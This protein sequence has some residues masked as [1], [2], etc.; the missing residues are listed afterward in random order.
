MAQE[1]VWT[2]P[3][4]G[5]TNI[6]I[7]ADNVYVPV[8][9][10]QLTASDFVTHEGDI[11]GVTVDKFVPA[12]AA[13]EEIVEDEVV[14][15]R[16]VAA[17]EAYI[18]PA[19]HRKATIEEIAERDVPLMLAWEGVTDPVEYHIVD[20]SVSMSMD[21]YF[22]DAW[23][24]SGGIISIDMAKAVDVHKNE[25]RQLRAPELAAL[26]TAYMRADEIGDALTKARIAARKQSLRDITKH[27]ELAAATTPAQL[28]QAALSVVNQT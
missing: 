18:I 7:P 3:V 28:K 17:Q 16:A 11:E 12:V 13:V 22:R 23:V 10:E 20:R 8:N 21:N 1:I 4:T 25:L 5:Q 15:Q 27:P 26:D 19:T 24:H 2:H 14:V 6:T 9:V